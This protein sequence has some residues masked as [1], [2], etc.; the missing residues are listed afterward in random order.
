MESCSKNKDISYYENYCDDGCYYL[1]DFV[2]LLGCFVSFLVNQT[3]KT[4]D[5]IRYWH[6]SQ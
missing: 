6:K 1:S 2:H 3:T 5:Q 4:K